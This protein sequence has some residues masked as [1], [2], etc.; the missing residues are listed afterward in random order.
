MSAILLM[1]DDSADM[2]A[3]KAH[4]ERAGYDVYSA[5]T[6]REGKMT[7]E[8]RHIDLIILGTVLPDGSGIGFC[9]QIRERYDIPVI[10]LTHLNNDA[11]LIA[12]LEAGGDEYMTKPYSLAALTARAE[13]LLRRVRMEKTTLRQKDTKE[14]GCKL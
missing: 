13:A 3:N 11:A 10:F 8:S 9:A 4:L 2:A 7:L 6:L 12:G 5:S 1:E 14:F